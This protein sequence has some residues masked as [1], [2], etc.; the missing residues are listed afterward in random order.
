[1]FV[2]GLLK[3]NRKADKEWTVTSRN[4]PGRRKKHYVHEADFNRYQNMKNK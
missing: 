2:L 4:K 1:M 3:G